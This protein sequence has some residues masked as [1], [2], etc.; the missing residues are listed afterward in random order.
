MSTPVQPSLP[1]TDPRA[2]AANDRVRALYEAHADAI[3]RRARRRAP[4]L[5][6][7][8]VSETFAVAVRRA[9]EIPEGRELPWLYVVAD[10]TL[11]NMMRGQRRAGRLTDALAPLVPLAADPVEP[12][13][14]GE[15]LRELP[16]RERA[17]LTMTAFEG[18]SA[19][20]A[21]DRLG[22]SYGTARNALVTGR[23]RLAVSLA[24]LAAAVV[25]AV[26]LTRGLPGRSQ[27]GA[28]PA[29][30][31]ASISRA[32]AIHQ[33]ALVRRGTG[34]TADAAARYDR[35]SDPSGSHQ[36]VVLPGGR[37]LTASGGETLEAAADRVDRGPGRRPITRAVREDLAALDVSSP[38][39]ITELLAQPSAS[40]TKRR[41]PHLA[42]HATTVVHGE[43]TTIAGVHHEVEAVIADGTPDVLRVRAQRLSA[44]RPVGAPSTVDFVQWTPV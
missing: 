26:V 31:K 42:G 7:D 36:R 4:Q 32:G 16:D 21:A 33:V 6:E 37:Q 30:L 2:A 25:L 34:G 24:A 20:E 40:A 23:R 1:S 19:G 39:S 29:V 38:A 10:F 11:Q 3:L 41:G 5:A 12:P 27:G 9:D 13:A 15:A 18:L 28:A 17:L 35:W 8:V 44:G 14:V 43:I 22:I